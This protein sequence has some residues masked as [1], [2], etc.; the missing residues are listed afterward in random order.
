M[1]GMH[2]GQRSHC[3]VV[4]TLLSTVSFIYSV[5]NIYVA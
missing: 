5:E 1:P 4:H 3:G 2:V